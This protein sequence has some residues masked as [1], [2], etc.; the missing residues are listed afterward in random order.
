[1]KAVIFGLGSIVATIALAAP[2]YAHSW[3]PK[4]CCND[5]DCAPVESVTRFVPAGGG[6]PQLIITSRH[7]SAIVVP[8]SYPVRESKDGRMHVCLRHSP[9]DPFGDIEIVCL[10]IPP[11]M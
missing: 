2:A 3:Y 8:E 11:S 9:S 7:G 6:S 5:G 1:M 10:F 4:D